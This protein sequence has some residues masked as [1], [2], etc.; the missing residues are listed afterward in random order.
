M[1]YVNDELLKPGSPAH[2][3]FVKFKKEVLPKL[4]DPVVFKSGRPIE[5]NET[6]L[7]EPLPLE[8]IPFDHN[9]M[10]E[11]GGQH[12]RYCDRPPRK[13]AD[14][15]FS[16][17]PRSKVMK[18]AWRFDKVRDSEQIF[19]FHQISPF[20]ERG[21][22]VYE[23]KER[24]ARRTLERET[25]DLDVRWMITGAKSPISVEQTGSENALR[26]LAAAWGVEDAHTGKRSISDIKLALLS[27]VQ[28]SHKNYPATQRG[29]KE[30]LADVENQELT[31]SMA[32]VQRAVDENVITYDKTTF[33]WR[34]VVS[35]TP[36]ATIPARDAG[37]P[38]AAL[39]KFLSLNQ[40]AAKILELALAEPYGDGPEDVEDEN[41]TAES[42]DGMS[43]NE[44]KMLCSE[45]KLETFGKMD[46][47][48]KRILD[49]Q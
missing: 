3:K 48:R 18:N 45:L 43:Y 15:N 21:N 1:L 27:A 31:S 28:H 4:Q 14:G 5:F 46:V 22:I 8:M 25:S 10:G 26:M 38:K 41:I 24:D 23:D 11:D 42:L 36:L 33:S 16:Y 7:P 44:L 19:F 6:G 12:W 40:N 29:Y 13:K 49:S 20:L 37:N 39:N 9:L 34:F 32:N 35:N 2:D 47:L 30:F 17:S